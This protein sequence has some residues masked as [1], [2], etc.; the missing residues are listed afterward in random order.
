MNTTRNAGRWPVLQGDFRF[1]GPLVS[2]IVT[3][4]VLAVSE[5][6]YHKITNESR[7]VSLQEDTAR[8]LQDLMTMVVD[9]ETGQR[10]FLLTNDTSYLEPYDQATVQIPSLI[11]A[12]RKNYAN[13]ETGLELLTHIAQAIQAKM[14]ELE[15]TIRL[16]RGGMLSESR[17]VLKTNLGRMKMDEV[18][19]SLDQLIAHQQGKT[20]RVRHRWSEVAASM[21]V[22]L[23]I[24]SA[25]SLLTFF[26]YLRF[27]GSIAKKEAAAAEETE[28]ERA[29]LDVE[30]QKRT[31]ELGELARNLQDVREQ[32]R[33]HIARELHDELGSLLTAAKLDLSALRSGLDDAQPASH[34]KLDQLGE[35]LNTVISLKRR[36][37]ESLHPSAL[38][39]LGPTAALRALVEDFCAHT[40]VDAFVQIEDVE[41]DEDTGLALYR[42][43]QEAL[44]NV[45]KYAEATEVRVALSADP[46]EITLSVRDNGRG[47]DVPSSQRIG[48]HGLAGMRIRMQSVGGTLRV[49]SRPGGGTLVQAT[50][51]RG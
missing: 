31:A 38:E 11:G 49:S 30:V 8:R 26:S 16:R 25:L 46:D 6:G 45:Q 4:A 29:R 39:H 51:P 41:L 18:R 48:S 43:T 10:G 44:T 28:R 32:E 40:D 9:A 5:Y 37:I 12:L 34:E 13:D 47:F 2:V 24:T 14:T 42:L 1:I 7:T 22:G 33:R 21:R 15:L 3:L 19:A 27:Y 35:T 17:A 36:I 50:V 20:A 23:A